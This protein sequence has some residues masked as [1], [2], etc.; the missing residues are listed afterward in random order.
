M[1][2][3][4]EPRPALD[5][6][7]PRAQR[8]RAVLRPRRGLRAT[9]GVPLPR[10]QRDLALADLGRDRRAGHAARRRPRRARHRARAARRDRLRH[11]LRVDPRRPRDQRR[12]RRH[13]HGLPDARS[14]TTSP[15]SWPTPT[16]ASCSPRTTSRSR[17]CAR[18]AP[19]CPQVIKVVTFDGDDRRRLGHRARRPGAARARSTSPTHPTSSRS[20]SPPPSR[21]SLA[22]LIYTS[23]T[24][25][26]PKGVRLVHDGWTYEGAALAAA[27]SS[28][29]DDLRV[30]LAADGALVR[31]G[32]ADRP[33]RRSASPC[34][35]DGRVPKIVE[36]LAI[37]KPTFMGAAPR[38]FEK[39]YGRIVGM[40]E[41][42]GGAKLKLFRWAE[43][44]GLRA[45][46]RRPRGQAG[47]A[48]RSRRKYAV[49]DKL[50]FSKVRERFGGR[51]RFF[52]SGAAALS[53]R[54]R[55]VVPRRG[56]PD[57]RGLRP[58][59]DVGRRRSSTSPTPSS[60]ARSACP[61]PGTEVKIAE[62]GEVLIKG[63]NVMRGYHN[64]DAESAS[65]LLDDG[66]LATGDIGEI[67]DDGFLRITDR[68]KDLFKT[69]GGKYVAPSHIEGMFKGIC[70][71]GQ[72]D[73]RPRQRPQLLLGAHHARSRRRRPRGPRS[74][75]M[76]GKSYAE[77]VSS[78][79]MHDVIAQDDRRAQ[80]QAQPLG[81]DQEVRDPRP[82]PL[83]RVR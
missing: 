1:S 65:A 53:H 34:A 83:G 44:V 30:P 26:R 72:P 12:R 47:V 18:S 64:L 2:M 52:I 28:A 10:R 9:R 46:A 14:P 22:T 77:I 8:R 35:I 71:A 7:E 21:T 69:S 48:G 78:P 81:D 31:Q 74:H 66:W 4:S 24:T 51:V 50:V 54:H 13:H 73:G 62:D 79:E 20:A 82:R 40:T 27:A 23:G 63:P 80:L 29:S 11:P 43:G 55:R 59:R 33:A 37:V 41:E 19:S 57:P 17:S 49:A 70:A 36:N 38:I 68:K 58:H 56:H 39:A 15:T 42:E 67:D 76:A 25:G 16:A 75:G 45:L 61:F 6:R 60:S 5:R 32:A 3:L